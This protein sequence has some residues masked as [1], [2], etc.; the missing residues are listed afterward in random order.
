MRNNGPVSGREVLMK[1]GSVIVS[2]TDEKGKIRFVN[3]DFVQISGFTRDEL[4]GQPHNLI[5][6]C[7][8]PPEAFE[9]MWRD[10]KAGKSWSGYVKNRIKNGDHYWVQANAMPC[11]ENGNI[12]GYISIRSKPDSAITQE[13]DKIYKQFIA[14]KAGSVRIEHGRF[15]DHSTM[16]TVR[17]WFKKFGAKITAMGVALCVLVAVVSGVGIYFKN[18][19]TQSLKTVYEDRTIPAGQL[20]ETDALLYTTMLNF[21]LIASGEEESAK[22]IKETEEAIVEI[23]KI[24]SAYMAT[25]LT[26]EEKILADQYAD[27]KKK[28]V[29]SGVIPALEMAK[30][31]QNSGHNPE[32]AKFL[33]GA[34]KLFDETQGTN[35]KL[36]Q[37]QLDVSKEAYEQAQKDSVTGLITTLAVT[38]AAIGIAFFTASYIRRALNARMAEIDSNL[39]SI[40]SGKYDNQIEVGD[41]ELQNTLTLVKA[42]QAKLAY[43]E[44]EKKELEQQKKQLQAQMAADFEQS[45]K[46]IVNI[47]AAAATELSQTAESMVDSAKDSANKAATASGAAASTT[48]NVQS[49]AAA[50]EELSATVKEISAQLQKTTHLVSDSREKAKNA[51]GVAN[52]LNEATNKVAAAMDMIANIAGQINL[53]AL[54]A[55]IESAR[56]GDA[57]KGF[58]VVASE[59]KNLASQADKTSGEIQLIVTEMRQAAQAIIAA[60]TEIGG[61]VG[62]ISEAASSVASAVEEQSATTGEISRN[63]QTAAQSTQSIADSLTDVQSSSSHAGAASEQMLMASRE[64]SKQ[65]EELNTQ[66]DNFL[67]RIRAA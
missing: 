52:V 56:A 34:H 4:I 13:V 37:L 22:L 33:L 25:Y 18:K 15:I 3:E 45:V 11:L 12:T 60:L 20:A 55:T 28:Y 38:L 42:L 29:E 64:L 39:N 17:R 47:L 53:L 40:A 63:M 67:R 19:T 35:K 27:Q 30:S 58:A 66:V 10:L 46:S 6:H 9:D 43:G 62:S 32:L 5:R 14:G 54:N 1:D 57:G 31:A 65:A 50:S 61:S 36:I 7:D 49:V 48:A 59:V 51:D 44:L 21:S 2:S 41:D 23:D 8:M 26:P 16:A 24:W